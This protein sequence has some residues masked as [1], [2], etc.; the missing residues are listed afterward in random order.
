MIS[1]GDS[2]RVKHVVDIL[3]ERIVARIRCRSE[4]SSCAGEVGRRQGMRMIAEN[5]DRE[6][7]DE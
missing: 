2:V 1:T 6:H 5:H 7:I 3:G 4:F